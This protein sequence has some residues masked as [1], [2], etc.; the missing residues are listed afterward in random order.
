MAEGFASQL[1]RELGLPLEVSS[2][3]TQPSG[4]VNPVAVEVMGEKGID[5]STHTSDRVA[6]EALRGYAAVITMGCSDKDV[7]P[8]NF[9]GITED[10]ALE[11]PIDRPIE[12][13]R[14]IRDQIE[15]RVT[16]LINRMTD[17]L[18]ASD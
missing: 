15:L 17:E 13:F 11:D 1:V 8:V 9:G 4:N 14:E 5:I 10:W 16:D 7:C 18:Y 2:A 12:F 3:G 6:P